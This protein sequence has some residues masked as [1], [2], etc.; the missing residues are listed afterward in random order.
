MWPDVNKHERLQAYMFF[1]LSFIVRSNSDA[2][3][4][5]SRPLGF[6]CA[7]GEPIQVV[8]IEDFRFIFAG[9]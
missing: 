2:L 8:D 5:P 7:T 4:K 9:E 1:C 6:V 3:I